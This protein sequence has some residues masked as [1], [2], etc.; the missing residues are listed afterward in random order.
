MRV[1]RECIRFSGHKRG[2]PLFHSGSERRECFCASA[3]GQ[4]ARRCRTFAERFVDLRQ[5]G[6]CTIEMALYAAD[7]RTGAASE[8]WSASTQAVFGSMLT[9]AIDQG[10]R[11]GGR[12]SG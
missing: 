8:H 6:V 9:P 2:L 1:K 3:D 12:R 11:L 10:E 7:G 4:A 5:R